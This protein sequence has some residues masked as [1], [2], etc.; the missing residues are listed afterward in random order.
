MNPHSTRNILR[1]PHL[2]LALLVSGAMFFRLLVLPPAESRTN[3]TAYSASGRDQQEVSRRDESSKGPK[4]DII[5]L[6]TILP[7]LLPSISSKSAKRGD[8][9]KCE[10]AQD[11]RLP[12][13][14]KIR[15]GAVLLGK[16]VS[17]ANADPSHGATLTIEFDALVEHGKS[18]AIRT[19][20]RALASTTEVDGA[21]VPVSGPGET[22]V[23]DWLTT[24]Q[25]GG[26]VV[27]GKEGPVARGSRIVGE[28]TYH[29]VFVRVRASAD[30]RCQG[31]VAEND[32]PQ[33]MW[34]F[35][36]DACGL[37]GFPDLTIRCDGRTEPSGEIVLE[38]NHGPVRIRRGS[39]ALL[40][41]DGHE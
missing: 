37:Y 2:G 11:V 30:G 16:V 41:V 35:A 12:G 15:Q 31:P 26:E 36:S 32:E 1:S 14:A 25:I 27:Y 9:I 33:A 20:L 5:P 21:Q 28:S 34:V 29:G 18:T 10:I 8:K 23:Y 19:H 7:V 22:D 40:R 17:V 13:G 6:G 39:G 3:P 38:S 24:E 4:G